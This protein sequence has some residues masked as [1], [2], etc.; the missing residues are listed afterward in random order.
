[1]PSS[2]PRRLSVLFDQAIALPA[3]E[4]S[5]FIVASCAGDL[6]LQSRLAAMLHAAVGGLADPRTH[7]VAAVASPSSALDEDVGARIGPYLLLQQLG[8]GGFGRVFLAQQSEPV[9]RQVALKVIKLGMDTRQVVARFE[10]ER[11]A[12]A[13]MDHPHIARVI[14]AGVT[15]SGRPFFVMDLVRG[16]SII[17][18]CDRN[19][20]SI[21][22][23]LAIFVQVCDAVQH[24]HGKG[25]IHR[26][27]KPSNVLVTMQDG[28][29]HT[30]VI[31]FGVAK[32]TSQRLTDKTLYTE[33]RQV[34]GTL[35][36]MSPEQA[37]GS[38]DVDIRTDV[39]S[40]GVLLY[41]LLTGGTPFD[42]QLLRDAMPGELPRLIRDF[43]PQTPSTRLSS[44]GEHLATLATQRRSEPRR[45]GALVRGELDWIV[46]KAIEKD[47][48]R[49]YETAAAFG[50]DVQRHLRGEAVIAA[51]PS[52]TYLL[53][54]F[55]RRHRGMV[56]AATAVA[57]ALVLGVVGTSLAL[58]E[59]VRE[60]QRA[61]LEAT[62][63][64]D[65]QHRAQ[66]NERQAVELAQRA[67]LAQREEA[68][69]RQH[70]E[71]IRD[72]V[73][74]ALREADVTRAGGREDVTILA[75]MENAIDDLDSGRFAAEPAIAADLK[76]TIAQVLHTNGRLEA[77][78]ALAEQA[79][80]LLRRVHSGDHDDLAAA[81]C[82]VGRLCN[83][84]GRL[85]DCERFSREAMS[86]YDRLYAGDNVHRASLRNN[87]G[88]VLRALG[89]PAEALPLL[90]ESV[91]MMRRLGNEDGTLAMSLDNLAQAKEELGAEPE[92]QALL[93]EALSLRRRVYV[94]DHPDLAVGINNVAAHC[95]SRGD[96]ER[97]EQL[98]EEALAMRR[99]MFH[100]DHPVVAESLLNLAFLR[101]NNDQAAAAAVLL[102]EGLAMS[103]RLF[104]GDHPN[105]AHGLFTLGT[106]RL[107]LGDTAAA[108]AA[109][110][111]SLVMHQALYP[112]DHIGT[113]MSLAQRARAQALQDGKAASAR[114]DYDAAL[115]MLR[116]MPIGRSPLREV[117]WNSSRQRYAAGD[118]EGAV[119]EL[120][121]LVELATEA[122]APDSPR[123]Q[124][125]RAALARC[126]ELVEN[127]G[128]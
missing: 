34:I 76:L 83:R 12:L 81:I 66:A 72:F 8:E 99:R 102:D 105:V 13:M 48:S 86:M 21:A 63:A 78:L 116:R 96:R 85:Q 64:A 106:T 126:R 101:A 28:R 27:L 114:A 89:R 22:E 14:D 68:R 50:L 62:A 52:R 100:G 112:G 108:E 82:E 75:A 57:L 103:Q 104:P 91:S 84:L 30:K 51:P 120:E 16:L 98:F 115:A 35:Q 58:V 26:D 123:L 109:F 24:A 121:E 55:V 61:D 80:Q 19:Q 4:R 128:K 31:D 44:S 5:A 71:T 45:L 93:E 119:G 40:L 67:E 47:R 54:K 11:Q 41:E 42:R 39:Y 37:E 25:V 32:A 20:L 117:L 125:Y 49:R 88:D 122:L 10:Q 97:A 107:A 7:S 70:A 95:W 53:R 46:M 92:A 60:R 90:E 65:A 9:V 73:V 18:H 77:A 6:E 43:E 87:V 94:G 33:Q 23:R 111:R 29:P 69:A 113:A 17:E 118:I 74:A 36:Y 15:A 59:A 3:T 79:V 127:G 2:D 38:L 110:A 124:E 56:M 1:M